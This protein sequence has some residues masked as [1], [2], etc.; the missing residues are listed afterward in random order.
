L[1]LIKFCG[2]KS[3]YEELNLAKKGRFNKNTE[4]DRIQTGF[5]SGL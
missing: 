1:K 2:E 5:I 3:S 4:D